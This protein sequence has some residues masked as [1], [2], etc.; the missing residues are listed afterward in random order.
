M[1]MAK[2]GDDGV[3]AVLLLTNTAHWRTMSIRASAAGQP[4]RCHHYISTEVMP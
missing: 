4:V 2:L 3:G 1:P